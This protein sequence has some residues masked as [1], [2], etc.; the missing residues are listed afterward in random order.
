MVDAA[1]LNKLKVPELKAKLQDLGLSVAGLK[2]DLVDR[3]KKALDE[4]EAGSAAPESDNTKDE[5][6]K[7]A[8]PEAKAEEEPISISQQTE[9]AAETPAKSTPNGRKRKAAAVEEKVEDAPDAVTPVAKKAKTD[10]IAAA[11]TQREGAST[12]APAP[13]ASEAAPETQTAPAVHAAPE[14][15]SQQTESDQH[16][17][18]PASAHPPAP[19]PATTET[20]HAVDNAK[21]E[22]SAPRVAT[23]ATLHVAN[24]VRPFTLPQVH[25]LLKQS[26]PF[27]DGSF[28]M[29]SIKSQCYVTYNSVDDATS[30][31]RHLDGLKWPSTNP[32]HLKV[33]CVSEEEAAAAIEGSKKKT[34]A[35]PTEAHADADRSE[36]RLA[37]ERER[38]KERLAERDR[39][40]KLLEQKMR[41]V[42]LQRRASIE[43]KAAEKSAAKSLDDLFRKTKALPHLYYLPLTDAEVS[44]RKAATAA[45][46][47]RK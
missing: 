23:T 25:A 44:E 27:K 1:E 43:G 24:F 20:P 19:A 22:P 3:L 16:A 26:A 14:T 30:S 5:E 28:W 33:T 37:E 13:A 7:E 38:E 12:H 21:E 29:D 6:M 9:S 45:T 10:D 4:Q 34:T 17:H 18:A 11:V 2:K 40:N 36:D 32:K 46:A 8:E 15:T 35:A 31:L 42:E 41:D 47:A 39:Q